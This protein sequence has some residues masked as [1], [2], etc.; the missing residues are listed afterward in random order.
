MQRHAKWSIGLVSCVLLATGCSDSTTDGS[1]GNGNFSL[2][3]DLSITSDPNPVQFAAVAI[4]DHAE[5]TVTVRHNGTSGTLTL[6]NVRFET[7]S[8]DLTMAPP[9]ASQLEPGGSTTLTIYYDPTDDTPDSGI[10]R[11][12]TNIPAGAGGG[13]VVHEI[14]VNS[15][16]QK[17]RLVA[18]PSPLDFGSVETAETKTETL[19]VQNIGSQGVDVI[20]VGVKQGGSPDFTVAQTPEIPYFAGP[21][22]EFEIDVSY[23]PAFDPVTGTFDTAQLFVR[24]STD[25]GEEELTVLLKG[26]EVSPALVTFPDVVDFGMREVDVTHKLPLNISNQGELDLVVDAI[27]VEATNPS[28]D[29]SGTVSIED[30]PG[31]LTLAKGESHQM[32][33]TFTPPGD[34]PVITSPIAAIRIASND[35]K[36]EGVT[37]VPVFG[38]PESPSLQVNPPEFV[39]FGFVAQNLTVKRNISMLNAGSA[40]LNVY[41]VTL[42]DGE[43]ALAD[44]W[45]LKANDTWE[46]L[47]TAPAAGI[48][49]PSE[50]RIA[51]VTFTN[52]GGET[53]TAWAKLIIESDDPEQPTW[54]LD[55]K[56][57][58][59]GSPVCEAK[60]VPDQLD[61]GIVPRGF[62]RTMTMNL[63]I[64]GSGPCSF[65]SALVIDCGAWGGF[66]GTSCDDPNNVVS[67]NGNSDYYTIGQT[68]PAIAGFLKPGEVHP[69]EI[70]FTPP[71]TA[72]I[73]G[74]ELT[75][76]AGLFAVRLVDSNQPGATPFVISSQPTAGP[77]GEGYPPNLHA[78][79]GLAELSVIPQE[80]DFGLITIG[81]TSQTLTVHAYNVGTAPLD[82]TNFE[83]VGCSPEF[84]LKDY[85]ALDEQDP[86]GN[87]KKT[88]DPGDELTF[89]IAYAPQDETEDNCSLAIYT[90]GADTPAAV[91]PLHGGGTYETEHT[92]EFIQTSG[93]NVDVLFV[94]DNSGSMGEE[95]SNLAVNFGQFINEAS[96]WNNDYQVGVVTTDAD[97]GSGQ[98]VGDP[99]FV[100][101]L[102]YSQFSDNVE[103][104]TNGS[105]TEQGLAAAQMALSLPNIADSSTACTADADCA[106]LG[107]A[108]VDGFCGGPNRGFLRKDAA[109]EI[110]IVS[111]EDDQ[112]PSDLNFYINFFKNIK[113][114]F[115]ENLLHVHAIVGLDGGCSSSDGD[116]VEGHRYR[117]VAQATGGNEISICEPDF[118]DG[119]QSI[120]EIAFGL[121]VQ[122]FLTRVAEPSTIEVK[123]NDVPCPSNGG[124]NW[125]YDEPSNSVVFVEDGACMPQPGE[126]VWI[127]Y[128]TICYLE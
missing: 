69:I 5:Q 37:S 51:E 36:G 98:L 103:V 14:P 26:N 56:A 64:I 63:E 53:G 85:P 17:A 61:Y 48:L 104:G 82:I 122:F 19:R 23:T 84:T 68:P 112:S 42:V 86:N 119:L 62:T 21:V 55:L 70:T 65:H 128:E 78:K 39:D 57:Q 30:W 13:T 121:K 116:A 1:G 95:Q 59:A 50:N 74:D 43:G 2:T 18:S 47:A 12:D 126:K 9:D 24:Y 11:I 89:D 6:S 49:N 110:V 52:L 83:L 79:S 44:E 4:G 7:A 102:N 90:N 117:A 107:T 27:S 125:V 20:E 58:R 123:V 29:W 75:D 100:T 38:R 16:D 35:L 60:L 113:G 101:N 106:S 111:D 87:F 77:F 91:V 25:E 115:N 33:V 3:D 40:P 46:P 96:T 92:D 93:Q 45:E 8:P 124:A 94:V 108:C 114:F 99:R 88:M 81:C 71:E 28:N 109:L 127:H 22:S 32:M 120:G 73:F 34:M 41:S 76:Y 72:P 15:L 66:F 80:I 31:T 10:V 54:E 118:A 67:L 105:G 97:A